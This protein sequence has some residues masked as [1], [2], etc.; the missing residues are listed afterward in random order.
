MTFYELTR[1]YVKHKK[2]IIFDNIYKDFLKVVL[3]HFFSEVLGIRI[4]IMYFNRISV[5]V[6]KIFFQIRL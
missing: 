2:E 5:F 6:L 1:Y 3:E 4:L